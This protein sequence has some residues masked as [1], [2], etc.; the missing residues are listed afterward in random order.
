MKISDFGISDS[1]DDD[2]P[3]ALK[4]FSKCLF[5]IIGRINHGCDAITGKYYPRAFCKDKCF[6]LMTQNPLTE[7]LVWYTQIDADQKKLI[8]SMYK[9]ELKSN[10]GL[11]SSIDHFKR[12]AALIPN[13]KQLS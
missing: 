10:C 2:D 7:G 4:S 1:V 13:P 8:I 5:N 6:E 9:E 12:S 3:L 11:Q